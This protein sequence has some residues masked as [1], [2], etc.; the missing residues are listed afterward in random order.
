LTLGQLW[1]K[2]RQHTK[3][4]QNFS[5]MW[6]QISYWLAYWAADALCER[7][8][9]CGGGRESSLLPQESNL[10]AWHRIMMDRSTTR[11]DPALGE[12]AFRVSGER[13]FQCYRVSK[14]QRGSRAGIGGTRERIANIKR[15]RRSQYSNYT[16]SGEE[17]N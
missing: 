4:D 11:F 10:C 12:R 8:E 17:R 1:S 7:T 5:R 3:E 15:D 14:T 9:G 6:Q 2:E 16:R 13:A